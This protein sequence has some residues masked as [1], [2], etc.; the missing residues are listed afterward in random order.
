[1][2]IWIAAQLSVVEEANTYTKVSTPFTAGIEEKSVSQILIH[3]YK[4]LSQTAMMR[5]RETAFLAEMPR[6]SDKDEL[7][8]MNLHISTGNSS[9]NECPTLP[10][11]DVARGLR[12]EVY[13]HAHPESEQSHA[14]MGVVVAIGVDE[15]CTRGTTSAKLE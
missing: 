11:V 4:C 15:I 6:E 2:C 14:L 9:S 1:M 5:P 8:W 13:S 12:R 7:N 3:T 10:G